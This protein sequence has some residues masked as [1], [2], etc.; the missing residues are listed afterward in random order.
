[1]WSEA[2]WVRTGEEDPGHRIG[3]SASRLFCLLAMRTVGERWPGEGLGGGGTEELPAMGEPGQGCCSPCPE[4]SPYAT[5]SLPTCSLCG[6]QE[7]VL[8]FY[9]HQASQ[10][11]RGQ[12]G[13]EL[14]LRSGRRT[15]HAGD[16]AA[17]LAGA[18]PSRCACPAGQ[19]ASCILLV[20]GSSRNSQP[21]HCM[22]RPWRLLAGMW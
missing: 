7:K 13:R 5:V 12:V 4:Q 15:G 10:D 20:V 1:M 19:V 3:L 2:S 14:G 8:G 11:A 18:F 9:Q 17:R 21:E 22:R 6:A 16:G